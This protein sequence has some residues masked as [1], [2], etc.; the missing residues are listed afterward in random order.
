MSG[1][2]NWNLRVLRIGT[3]SVRLHG[4]LLGLIVFEIIRWSIY[5]S[6]GY[7]V[8]LMA[9]MV[10]C[11][12]IHELAHCLMA[13][14]CRLEIGEMNLWPLG[15]MSLVGQS[16][17]PGEEVAVALGGPIINLTVAALFAGMWT[18]AGFALD[19]SMLNPLTDWD[20]Y[21]LAM[22][23]LNLILAAVNLL[24]PAYPLDGG[25]IANGLLSMWLGPYRAILITSSIAVLM[26][27]MLCAWGLYRL[28]PVVVFLA[29]FIFFQSALT[30]RAARYGEWMDY[31][32]GAQT[33]RHDQPGFF[34]RWK[35][36]RDARRRQKLE[37]ER[38]RVREE[39]DLILDKVS[40]VGMAGLTS[41]EKSQLEEASRI[42]REFGE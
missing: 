3:A 42:M 25:R 33:F 26:A 32:E 9:G 41:A 21:P 37:K 11:V 8:G 36:R 1:I 15:S 38:R 17:T 7:G 12:F 2:W 10:A 13:H 31:A 40:R 18:S 14:R 16:R 30:R 4:F 27:A 20:I 6:F 39:V 34:A 5:G 23:K 24:V 35:M 19:V 22:I 28:E 29:L